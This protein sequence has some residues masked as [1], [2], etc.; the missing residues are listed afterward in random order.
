MSKISNRELRYLLLKLGVSS[1]P[2]GRE[3]LGEFV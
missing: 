1:I 2:T 3:L